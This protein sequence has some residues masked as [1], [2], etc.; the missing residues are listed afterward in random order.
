MD[1]GVRNLRRYSDLR[2]LQAA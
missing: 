2:D 1:L